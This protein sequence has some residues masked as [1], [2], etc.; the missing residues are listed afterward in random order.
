MSR[1]RPSRVRKM[2]D[3]EQAY[4]GAMIDGEGFVGRQSYWR[5]WRIIVTN[6]SYEI[7]SAMMRATGTGCIVYRAEGKG[8]R[9]KPQLQWAVQAQEDVM[10]IARQCREYSTKLQEVPA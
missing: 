5:H 1:R 9:L 10:D 3:V 4:V 2:N 7:I 8:R 6:T